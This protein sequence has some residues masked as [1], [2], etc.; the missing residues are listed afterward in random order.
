MPPVYPEF[1]DTDKRDLLDDSLKKDIAWSLAEGIDEY[2]ESQP[3]TFLG[4]WTCFKK[5][6]S[7]LMFEYLLT[8]L[9]KYIV[10]YLPMVSQ[11]P[12]YP[13]C[14]KFLDDLSDIIKE[15]DLDHIFA[16][17][18][19]LVYSKLVYILWKFPDIYDRVIVLMGGFHQLRVLQKQ[20]Y[21]RYACLNFKSW[22]IDSDVIAKGSLDQAIVG[23]HYYRSMRIL[24]ESFKAL[25]QYSFEKAMLENGDN[26]S[27]IKYVILNL[28][29]ET[30]SA[31]LEAVLQH[32]SFEV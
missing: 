12:E 4:S 26:F 28:R 1:H 31:N 13:V 27:E 18:D 16:H 32:F 21:K 8:Y 7:N 3:E 2:T 20:I 19:E 29:K 30:T 10:E 23:T 22:L 17:A 11:P 6:T 9:F 5:D 24:T 25:V 14:K 15:L